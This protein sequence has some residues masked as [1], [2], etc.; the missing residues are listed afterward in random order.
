MR[1]REFERLVEALG[2]L[3]PAQLRQVSLRVGE[4]NDRR[5]VQDLTDRRVDAMGACPHCGNAEFARWGRTATG[6]QRYRC[7]GCRKTFTSLTGTPFSRVHDKAKLLENAACMKDLLSV[8]EAADRM[9]VHRNTAFRYRHLM[10]PLLD[11]HQPGELQ[12]VAEADEAFFRRSYKG[13]KR[14]MPRPAHKRGT[15]A[16]K[17]GISREQVAVLTAIARG[18]RNSFIAVLPSVPSAAT[19]GAALGP[20][21]KPDAVLVSD[22]ASAYKTAAK[23]LGIVV[24]QIPRGTH[25]LGP[26]HIQNVN[27]LHSRIKEGLRPFRGVATKNLP[28]YLAWFR[29]FDRTA[30][31]AKPQQLLLDAIG[32]PTTSD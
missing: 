31:A 12:G 18:S 23:A 5:E 6:D 10:M 8:R 3:T 21:L 1:K 11:K 26:Y 14:G 4:L 28:V 22:S 19:V 27:A 29:F 20:V 25:K 16:S 9:G 7:A 2:G 17:R 32:V 15:P 24:R 30:G 13:Q